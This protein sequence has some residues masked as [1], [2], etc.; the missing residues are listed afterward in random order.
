[1]NQATAH[2]GNQ[3][4]EFADKVFHVCRWKTIGH[5]LI[6]SSLL[7]ARKAQSIAVSVSACAPLPVQRLQLTVDLLR[8][9]SGSSSHDGSLYPRCRLL[10]DE[11]RTKSRHCIRRLMDGVDVWF[12]PA[13]KTTALE[14][15]TSSIQTLAPA[16][17]ADACHVGVDPST[18]WRMH[19]GS[20]QH[21]QTRFLC[22]INTV[23]HW[24]ACH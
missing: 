18:M 15:K 10:R 2:T 21:H 16:L 20:L 14:K 23:V 7:D 24:R 11:S 17:S 22:G 4:D 5:S 6:A 8:S 1:M 13:A 3:W 12:R 9:E 19:H